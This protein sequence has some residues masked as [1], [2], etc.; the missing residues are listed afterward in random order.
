M[1]R[2]NLVFFS[3]PW[4]KGF[5]AYVDGVET[6]IEKV[7]YGFMAILV[8]EGEHSI[9]FVCK[10]YGIEARIA[11]SIAGILLAAGVAVYDHKK[12]K[13]VKV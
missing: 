6:P 1:S 7:D 5:T 13:L 8:P 3:I 12:N 11:A 10:P 4:D 2:D 9:R